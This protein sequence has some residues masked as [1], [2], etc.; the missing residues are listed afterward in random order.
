MT[1]LTWRQY[2]AQLYVG[3]AALAALTV[4]LLITGLQVASK[5]HSA[6]T[7]CAVN[8]SCRNLAT[9]S[10]GNRVVGV[11]VSLTVV[12]PGLLGMFWGAPLLAQELETGTSQLAWMQSVTR[13]RWLV[14]KTGWV[15]LAA[16]ALSGAVSALVTWWSG[17]HN[18]LQLD[19]FTPL[20][21][22]IMG[23]VPVAYALFAV[24][25]VSRQVRYC[26]EP[27]QRWAPP[28]PSSLRFASS[29]LSCSARTTWPPLRL[30]TS[31]PTLSF[32]PGPTG[33]SLRAL[34]TTIMAGSSFTNP[35]TGTGRSRA[36]RPASS[37]PSP[38]PS[39]P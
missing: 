25:E 28:S 1:W 7:A 8:H 3:A 19:A 4:L 30:P 10:L 36:S 18:V 27:C 38:P 20:R 39:S 21:F 6:L 23:I 24:A 33:G 17:P 35:P 2:R 34:P 32:Q 11:L 31:F 9:F 5:Y 37:S 29:S 15:L 16:A 14:V 26:A 12:V 13:K 22:D